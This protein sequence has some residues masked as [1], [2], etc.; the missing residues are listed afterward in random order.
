[1]K[2][3]AY[4]FQM[5]KTPGKFLITWCLICITF[6][7]L[8][9]CAQEPAD[10]LRYSWVVPGGTARQQAIGG[11]MGSLGGEISAAYVNPAG[12]GFYKTGDFVI[13]PGFSFS[14]NK[15]TYL[16][17]TEKDKKNSFVLGTT[18]VVLG[19][20]SRR[21]SQVSGSAFVIAIN[22]TANFNNQVLY[23]GLNNTTSYSQKF[24]EEIRNN[25][26]KDANVVSGNLDTRP[27]YYYGTSLAFNTYWIDTIGG[28][29]NGNYQFQSRAVPLLATGLIQ[30][31]R[32]IT[33]GGITELTLGG[34]A[35]FNDKFYVGGTLGIP[36]LN[37]NR[38]TTFTEADA[39]NNNLNQFNFATI[40]DIL[41]TRGVGL[42]L[43]AGLIYKPV[44]HVRLGLAAHT[45]T[46]YNIEEN[47]Q[48][49]ITTDTENYQGLLSQSSTEFTGNAANFKYYLAT[50]YKL[51]GSVSYVLREIED[52][53]NQRGFL[54]A[55]IEFINYKASSFMTD[56]T[57]DN[58]PSTQ[59]YFDDLNRVIDNT[60]KA[61]F[62][63][64]VGGELKFNTVMVRAGMA[65]YG[66]PY[67]NLIG[68]KGRRL[69]LSGGLGYRHRGMFIDLTYVHNMTR[70][71]HVPYRLQ[72]APNTL[73]NIRNTTGNAVLTVGF[74]I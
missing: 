52:V 74:K 46:I 33:S 54:T 42:N 68:E 6:F 65:Y 70:E 57:V 36:F 55:D 43:K 5:M 21:N 34:G 32:L 63:F 58:S 9:V 11:A 2:R 47:F 13:T 7:S 30:E 62:N 69:L 4:P 66:N 15:S 64:R 14:R 3:S 71:V 18:G 27:N 60:Y 25:N 51:I 44:E 73:A 24:L 20:G 45:P 37:Y 1:M 48:A 22:R 56:A 19:A 53:R 28:G 23:R 39:T 41:T 72:S 40:E 10:A 31:N 61:A 29:T 49:T 35:G 16:S 67:K 50:P 17:R 59:D 38:T 12:L 8:E 26:D